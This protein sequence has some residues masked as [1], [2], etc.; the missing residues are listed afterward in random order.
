MPRLRFTDVVAALGMEKPRLECRVIVEQATIALKG[1]D[2]LFV[3]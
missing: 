2:C 1:G 3:D